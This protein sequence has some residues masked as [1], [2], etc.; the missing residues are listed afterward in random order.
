MFYKELKAWVSVT[1][2]IPERAVRNYLLK[3]VMSREDYDEDEKLV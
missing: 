1:S 2:A 3:S